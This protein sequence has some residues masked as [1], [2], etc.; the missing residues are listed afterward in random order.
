MGNE[1]YPWSSLNNSLFIKRTVESW[2]NLLRGDYPEQIYHDF[3]KEHAGLFFSYSKDSVFTVVSKLKLA[4]ELE[5]DFVVV[6]D[7][8]SNGTIYEF[9]EIEKPSS[10][11]FTN[12]GIPASDFNMALQQVRDWKSFLRKEKKYFN[13]YLPTTSDFVIHDNN[14]KFT[15]IIGRRDLTPLQMEKRQDIA[16]ENN[17][18]I[19][20]FDYLSNCLNSNYYLDECDSDVMDAISAN[21]ILN[22]LYRAFTDAEW[23]NVCDK[24]II[25][26]F[27]LFDRC[28]KPFSEYIKPNNL[29]YSFVEYANSLR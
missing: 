23:R 20:S 13:K 7:G 21:H 17:I 6:K 25:R 16:Y 9:I 24:K 4:S 1:H 27:H 28:S 12:R 22:P 18:E 8:Y 2:E 29:F 3:I 5:T 14:I 19:R 15:I 26:N 10:K 11:L